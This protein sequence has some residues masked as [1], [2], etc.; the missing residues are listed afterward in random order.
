MYTFSDFAFQHIVIRLYTELFFPAHRDQTD[1]LIILSSRGLIHKDLRL[2]ET[3][4]GRNC[5][6]DVLLAFPMEIFHLNFFQ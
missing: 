6:H 2:L 3:L 1:M 5:S 4:V